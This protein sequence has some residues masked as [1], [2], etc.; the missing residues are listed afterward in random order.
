MR[1]DLFGGV[2]RRANRNV[3]IN[4]ERA[5]RRNPPFQIGLAVIL[6]AAKDLN[7]ST[8]FSSVELGLS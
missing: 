3:I 2:F 1:S 8:S 7:L 5:A 4:R 6:S